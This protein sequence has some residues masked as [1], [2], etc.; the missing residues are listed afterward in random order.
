[1]RTVFLFAILT[2][3]AAAAASL[4]RAE[5][6]VSTS[7]ASPVDDV[8]STTNANKETARFVRKSKRCF[9]IGTFFQKIDCNAPANST[10]VPYAA[11]V[12]L[13]SRSTLTTA[14]SSAKSATGTF[15]AASTLA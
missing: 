1:M 11:P 6:S 5:L 15:D 4:A 8:S 7:L 14:R 9:Y 10:K 13:S 3:P 12:P 2:L